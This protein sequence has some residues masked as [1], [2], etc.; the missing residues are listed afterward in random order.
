[1]RRSARE[2]REAKQAGKADEYPA[3]EAMRLAI[4]SYQEWGFVAWISSEITLQIG[5]WPASPN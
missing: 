2:A 4:G 5:D 1:M 3:V